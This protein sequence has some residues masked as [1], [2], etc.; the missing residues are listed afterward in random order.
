MSTATQYPAFSSLDDGGREHPE[1]GINPD[2]DDVA[3]A[4]PEAPWGRKADGTPR[5]KPGRP[6]GTPDK[7]PR[8][9]TRRRITVAGPKPKQQPRPKKP[10]TPDYR[11]GINGILQVVAA[12]LMVAGLKSPAL[13]ADAAAIVHHAEDLSNALQET[14]EQVPGFAAVLERVLQV[15]PY[16]ALLAAVMPLGMQLAV[17][18]GLLSTEIGRALG[19]ADPGD[20]IA[21]LQPEPAGA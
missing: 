18:H 13:A 6:T 4:D 11:P 7:A 2:L 5:A 17:N 8:T 12:P 15:G 9:R 16:G 20:L 14:A 21:S 10:T 3:G 1:N 19:A